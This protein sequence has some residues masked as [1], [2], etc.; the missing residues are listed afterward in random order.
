MSRTIFKEMQN[1]SKEREKFRKVLMEMMAENPQEAK[2]L[3]EKVWKKKHNPSR[4]D[5]K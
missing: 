5:K 1:M 3:S 4:R 2:K